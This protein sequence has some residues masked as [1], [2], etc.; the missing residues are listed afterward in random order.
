MAGDEQIRG[1]EPC[2]PSIRVSPSWAM[3]MLIVIGGAD[4]A[5]GSKVMVSEMTV[6]DTLR[7][8]G[9]PSWRYWLEYGC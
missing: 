3:T 8:G 4:I 1:L 5:R 6:G 7:R 2:E 9:G